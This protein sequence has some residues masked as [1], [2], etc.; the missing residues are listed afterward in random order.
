MNLTEEINKFLENADYN[1]KSFKNGANYM[2]NLLKSHLEKDLSEIR[3][4]ILNI[5]AENIVPKEEIPLL[6]DISDDSVAFDYFYNEEYDRYQFEKSRYIY[7][8]QLIKELDGE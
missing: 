7:I 4:F 2:K 5:A 6:F 3:N 8:E 1:E